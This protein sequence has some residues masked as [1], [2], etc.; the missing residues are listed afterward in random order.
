MSVPPLLPDA[1][2]VQSGP[3][4][5]TRTL[6]MTG[7]SNTTHSIYHEV[8]T[9]STRDKFRCQYIDY[10][11]DIAMATICA[12]YLIFGAVYS[13]FGK[14]FFGRFRVHC[15]RTRWGVELQA[16]HPYRSIQP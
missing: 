7:S 11:Y 4:V 12:M 14:F 16:Q 1:E 10:H 2:V 13:L 9:V 5:P 8:D 15:G 6:N 3:L